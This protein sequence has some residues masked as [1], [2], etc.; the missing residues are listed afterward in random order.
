MDT[1]PLLKGTSDLLVLKALSWGPMHGFGIS[2]LL[3][4]QSAGSIAVDD[5]AMYQVLHRLEAKGFVD[6][7]WRT[8]ENKRKARYYRITATGRKHL[9][10]ET[11]TWLKYTTSVSGILTLATRPAQ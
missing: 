8:T 9:R 10:A 6:A 5:S 7:E 2:S 4:S 11:E 1:L 3:E